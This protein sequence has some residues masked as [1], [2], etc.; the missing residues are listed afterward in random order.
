MKHHCIKWGVLVALV[1]ATA[2]TAM[3]LFIAVLPAQAAQSQRSLPIFEVDRTWP[4]VP[5]QW[6]LGDPSSIAIDAQDN[7]WVL[8]RPRTLKP[9][10]ATKAAPPVIVFDPAGNYV[11]AWGG[12][13]KGYEWPQR[14]HGIH[15]DY[16]ASCGSAE[17]IALP[18]ACPVSNRSPTTNS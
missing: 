13:G 14:E 15:I 8:H 17:T 11:K 6:K 9:E 1:F 5:P 12:D 3:R 7:V 10:E 16:K 4:K 2:V 18:M